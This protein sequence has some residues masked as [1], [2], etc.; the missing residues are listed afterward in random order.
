M[1]ISD[2]LKI[3]FIHIPKTG[4]GTIEK[5][6]GIFGEDNNGSHKLN[7]EILYGKENNRFL[8]HL[9]LLE[10]NKI[11]DKEINN[12]KKISFVRN[13]YDKILSEYQWRIQI[14]G[15]KKIDF[16]KY[17][18]E[19]VIPRKNGKNEFIKN[20]YKDESLIPF[21]DSHYLDQYK[22]LIDDKGKFGTDF[23]GKFENLEE[24]FYKIFN[25]KIIKDQIHKSKANYIYYLYKKIMPQFLKKKA[26]RK[27][28]D[29]ESRDLISKE[30]S[31]DLEFFKYNF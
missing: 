20:F 1:P 7:Y 25:F 18:F 12:Y 5:S 29:S 8:Q 4:G 13:P 10:I 3:I 2:K 24:D 21:M 6:L 26:Y 27:F 11:K 28:Y 23:I 14:Y 15:K 19:E 16:K 17:L 9:T 31:K 22:F 30:Y